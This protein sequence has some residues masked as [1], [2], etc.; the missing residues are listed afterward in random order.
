M[1]GTKSASRYATALLD[2]SEEQNVLDKVYEDMSFLRNLASENADFQLFLKS[3]II[4]P[5]KKK[6]IF[7]KLFAGFNEVTLKFALLM[8]QNKRE[9]ILFEIASSFI[10][11]YKAKKGIVP[12]KLVTA[13]KLDNA[14]KKD[15]L[16]KIQK[17]V[18][19]TIELTE[20]I[21]ESLIGGFVVH[22]GDKRIDASI[23]SRFNNLKQHLAQ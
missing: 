13:F 12:V 9:N 11:Q 19:G 2:L 16:N 20:Q 3:P 18:K 23:A 1:A 6:A 10:H 21:D 15:I 4:A 22:M 7:E 17:E 8:T 5:S 14:V